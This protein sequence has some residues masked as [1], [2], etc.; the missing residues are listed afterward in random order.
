[1]ADVAMA[2]FVMGSIG[3]ACQDWF[4]CSAVLATFYVCVELSLC[5]AVIN[6]VSAHDIP[7][8]RTCTATQV[9]AS[10]HNHICTSTLM[11]FVVYFFGFHFSYCIYHIWAL[12]V[13]ALLWYQTLVS[14]YLNK[15]HALL[16]DCLCVTNDP[17]YPVSVSLVYLCSLYSNN[18]S[19]YTVTHIIRGICKNDCR[20]VVDCLTMIPYNQALLV[21]AFMPDEV[22]SLV[23][24]DWYE[25]SGIFVI[26]RWPPN[27]NSSAQTAFSKLGIS[28]VMQSHT[29]WDTLVPAL[30]WM[31]AFN[32][33]HA[34][35]L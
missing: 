34:C 35:L 29:L 17:I 5:C 13:A 8:C 6:W 7:V 26:A 1:M 15:H 21:N 16:W 12:Y 22:R 24:P 9:W 20:H 10:M 33:G 19:R 11:A 23:K 3:Y 30:G 14:H 31:Q 25:V 18:S 32:V 28:Q 4:T 27:S 2:D